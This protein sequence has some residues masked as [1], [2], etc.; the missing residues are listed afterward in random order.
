MEKSLA[1]VVR[2]SPNII[3]PH[4]LARVND[5]LNDQAL[6]HISKDEY[7]IYKTPE[8]VLYDKSCIG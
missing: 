6:L 1:L 5:V 2:L 7:F 8:G 3:L 4:L